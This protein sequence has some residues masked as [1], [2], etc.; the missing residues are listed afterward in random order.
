MAR[1]LKGQQ[2]KRI[3]TTKSRYGPDAYQKW[4]SKG[5]SALWRKLKKATGIGK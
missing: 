3:K 2:K 4:G 1:Y 5:G